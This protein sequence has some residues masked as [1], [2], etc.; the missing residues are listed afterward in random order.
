MLSKAISNHNQ[1]V[2]ALTQK[3]FVD[4][5]TALTEDEERKI[6]TMAEADWNEWNNLITKMHKFYSS[7]PFLVNDFLKDYFP[8]IQD[9][10]LY[11]KL[12]SNG[13]KMSKN[14]AAIR[15]LSFEEIKVLDSMTEDD[16]NKRK[17]RLKKINNIIN[18]NGDGIKTYKEIKKL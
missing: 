8:N 1:L 11:K 5:H 2:C 6:V 9:R 3:A 18:H 7:N 17:T 4:Q 13:S 12:T 16:W 15:S 14:E 10:T